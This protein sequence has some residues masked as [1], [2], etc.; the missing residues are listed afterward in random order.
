MHYYLQ[1]N[2]ELDSN[3]VAKYCLQ[4]FLDLGKIQG[5]ET[6]REFFDDITHSDATAAAHN[7]NESIGWAEFLERNRVFIGEKENP[8]G[9]CLNVVQ[10]VASL[11]TGLPEDAGSAEFYIEED[12][13]EGTEHHFAVKSIQ[14]YYKQLYLNV[15]DLDWKINNSMHRCNLTM[16]LED[17]DKLTSVDDITQVLRS[18]FYHDTLQTWKRWQQSS[19][20]YHRSQLEAKALRS[21]PLAQL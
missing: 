5:Y 14:N 3:Y 12:F 18:I 2:K 1:F 7:H 17:I 8:I 21:G 6:F 4:V 15:F 9:Q 16:P 10:Y 13:A 11:E 19:S 20:R